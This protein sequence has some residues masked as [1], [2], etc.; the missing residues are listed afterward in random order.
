MNWIIEIRL[1]GVLF[2]PRT[3]I[4]GQTLADFIGEL[5]LESPQK[6]DLLKGWILNVDNQGFR[7]GIVLT[8][9]EGSIIELSYSLEF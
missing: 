2:K 6:K 4:K 7:V 3:T 9:P 5:T 1:L 8:T